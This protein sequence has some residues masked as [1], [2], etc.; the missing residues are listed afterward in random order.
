LLPE[1]AQRNICLEICPT[2]YLRTNT[3][4]DLSQ[5]A[6]VFERC[7]AHSV[8]ISIATDNPALHGDAGRIVGQ[9]EALVRSEVI[10]F[11]DILHYARTGYRYAFAPPM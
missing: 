5:L 10:H 3:L 4:Q 1:L 6:P 9:Y 8:P 7:E 2:T 11:N